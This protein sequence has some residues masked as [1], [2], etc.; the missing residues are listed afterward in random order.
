VLFDADDMKLFLLVRGFQDCSKIERDLNR[1]K[2]ITHFL[3]ALFSY[4]ILN[5]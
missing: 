5:T 4:L 1:P 2:T 3:Y